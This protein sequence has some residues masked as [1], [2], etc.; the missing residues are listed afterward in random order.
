MA[1]TPVR[2]ALAFFMM[3]APFMMSASATADA[4][5]DLVAKGR[6]IAAEHC[7]RCH[8]IG[9][10]DA[11]PHAKAPPFRVVADSYPSEHLAEALAEGFV[12]GHPD[13]PVYVFGT[14]EIDAFLAYL[15]SLPSSAPADKTPGG[16]AE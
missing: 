15:D 12:S 6:A 4:V 7:A 5:S 2:A 3:S 13:M 9:V 14:Q 10:S 11:S 8:A 1:S 16:K